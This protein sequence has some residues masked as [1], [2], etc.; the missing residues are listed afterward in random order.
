MRPGSN[1]PRKTVTAGMEE[2]AA[3]A[4]LS[5]NDFLTALQQNGVAPQTLRDFTNYRDWAGVNTPAARFPVPRP[6]DTRTKSTVP[7]VPPAPAAC[8][9]C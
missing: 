2:L 1:R 3:R 5:L 6:S 8:K 4:N 7:W 9:C